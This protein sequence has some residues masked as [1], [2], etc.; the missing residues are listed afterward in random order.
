M[1]LK[2]IKFYSF[3]FLIFLNLNAVSADNYSKTNIIENIIIEFDKSKN[4]SWIKNLFEASVDVIDQNQTQ[5]FFQRIKKKYSRKW[6][7]CYLIYKGEKY[8]AQIRI[9]GE[10]KDHLNLPTSSLKVK[11]KQGHISNITR[12]NLFLPRTRNNEK[13]VFWALLMNYLGLKSLYTQMVDISFM[14]TS[15]KAIFQEDTAKEYL[16]RSGLKE[17]LILKQNDFY[18]FQL[19]N[20]SEVFPEYYSLVINNGSFLKNRKSIEIASN[21]ISL[22]ISSKEDEVVQNNKFFRMINIKYASHG[23]LPHNRKFIYK[24]L[25]NIFEEI[26]YDGSVNYKKF[27]NNNCKNEFTDKLKKF[28]KHYFDLTNKK[29]SNI[30]K[31]IF[32][33]KNNISE[34]FIQKN[35]LPYE[36]KFHFKNDLD[37]MKTNLIFVRSNILNFL[38]NKEKKVHNDNR[39]LTFSFYYKDKYYLANYS[40]HLKKTLSIREINYKKYKDALRGRLLFNYLNQDI[41]VFNL[42]NILFEQKIINL[43]EEIFFN[44]EVMLTNPGTYKFFLN[45]NTQYDNEIYFDSSNVKLVIE[46][47]MDDQDNLIF[48]NTNYLND[49]NENLYRYDENLLNGCINFINVQFNGGF[50]NSQGMK[51]EDSVNIVKSQGTIDKI[52][53]VDSDFDGLDIDI[54]NIYIKRIDIKNA[55]NDCLDLSFGNY[56]FYIIHLEN[57]K[58]KAISVGEKSFLNAVDIVTSDSNYGIVSKDSSKVTI[59]NFKSTRNK[60]CV[61]AYKKKQEFDGGFLKIDNLQCKDFDKKIDI[62]EFSEIIISNHKS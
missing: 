56:K 28:E 7:D 13:E 17:T 58:D 22:F 42:G 50:I 53:I 8:R 62:D 12:F 48:K 38:N 16:E 10:L 47:Q 60:Y 36:N 15:Y 35:K 41:P 3:F 24:P 57:C 19:E 25:E 32:L 21:A 43:K 20:K 39:K 18:D 33:E 52:K 55:K 9:V 26:Y 40:L 49:T 29:L 34:F 31:C 27:K 6:F 45:K 5:T 1:F 54:S 23:M 51:C 46:G 37:F 2:R 11:L 61:A 14:G 44:K 4:R 30:E 59:G